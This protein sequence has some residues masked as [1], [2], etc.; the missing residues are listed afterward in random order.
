MYI[1]TQFWYDLNIK[2]KIFEKKLHVNPR[3][4]LPLD[5]IFWQ[6][7]KLLL[8]LA[9]CSA[10]GATFFLLGAENY[11]ATFGRKSASY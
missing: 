2:K 4:V 3:M 9:F 11:F 5:E 1:Y 6:F 10:L 7:Y 8:R